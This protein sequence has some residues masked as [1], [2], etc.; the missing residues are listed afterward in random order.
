MLKNIYLKTLFEKRWVT[1]WW[2]AISFLLILAIVALFPLFKDSFG[3]LANVP[4]ELKSLVGDAYAYSTIPGWLNFQVFDQMVFI[5]IILGI[6]IGGGILAGEENEGTLQ[7]LMSLPIKRS[8]V[9][10]QKFAAIAS[11][12]GAVTLCLLIGSWLGVALIGES[13]SVWKLVLC[14][15][16]AFLI[17]VFFT[18]L[19]Y[20]LGAITGK[21]SLAGTVVGLFAFASFMISSLAPG[22]EALKYIDHFS[23]FH[24]YN[25]PSPL[26]GSFQAVDAL[27]VITATIALLVL[28]AKIFARRDI[29]QR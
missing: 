18:A 21:R 5:G 28:G 27:V 4:D 8:T 20:A 24:Y 2:F 14:T 13:V 17:S 25:E 10:W 16:M 22:I 3:D 23:P 19:T 11:I 26:I 1:F 6:I 12:V 9:Y 7:S 29:Y 15:L